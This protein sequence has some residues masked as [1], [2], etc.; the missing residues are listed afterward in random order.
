MLKMETLIENRQTLKQICLY[1][2]LG[3]GSDIHPH[4][5]PTHSARLGEILKVLG[6]LTGVTGVGTPEPPH[7]KLLP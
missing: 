4:Q 3:A 6:T 1:L 2:F 5:P 7:L